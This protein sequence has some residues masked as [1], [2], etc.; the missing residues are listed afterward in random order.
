MNIQIHGIE[1]DQM[2]VKLTN[3]SREDVG[4]LRAVGGGKWDPIGKFWR[5]PWT[6]EKLRQFAECFPGVEITLDGLTLSPKL[7]NDEQNIVALEQKLL[8][9][10]KLKGYSLKTSKAYRGHVRRFLQSQADL[11][12]MTRSGA[13]KDEIPNP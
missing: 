5:F 10:L 8:T 3:F 2:S 1:H 7:S 4:K 11:S 6:E 12:E 13:H 9:A